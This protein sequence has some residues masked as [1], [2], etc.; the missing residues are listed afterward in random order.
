MIENKLSFNEISRFL[1]PV[2]ALNC[3]ND[4]IAGFG[5]VFD[6]S[7]SQI[8]ELYNYL[9]KYYVQFEGFRLNIIDIKKNTEDHLHL[10]I[11]FR[12]DDKWWYNFT[13][14]ERI[15]IK[16]IQDICKK[17]IYNL[18][19]S[20]YNR[21]VSIKEKLKSKDYLYSYYYDSK[22]INNS[23]SEQ[24]I[25]I[26]PLIIGVSNNGKYRFVELNFCALCYEKQN[27]NVVLKPNWKSLLSF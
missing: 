4:S 23:L 1:S 27:A 8:D 21:T 11:Q 22:A 12:I 6:F 10:H 3:V 19:F 17:Q 9:K 14:P 16:A 26:S 25:T 24:G 15:V 2:L 18:Q 7:F 20:K 13:S 5:K